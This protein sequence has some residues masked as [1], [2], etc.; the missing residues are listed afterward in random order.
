[1]AALV[2]KDP[3]EVT[4]KTA[5]ASAI[6]AAQAINLTLYTD[7]SAAAVTSALSSAQ[8]VYANAAA[9]QAQADAATA[10]LNGAVASLVLKQTPAE[11]TFLSG[12]YNG[13]N[14]KLYVP[15]SHASGTAAPLL[16]ML[17]G[18]GQTPTQFASE[19]QMN[20][21]ADERG[22]LVLYPEQPMSANGTLAW[23]W[24]SVAHQSRGSGEPAL[25]AGM[26]GAVKTAYTID[27]D[28]VFASGMGAGGAMAVILGA[29][30]PD[31]FHGIGVSS[32]LEYKAATSVLTAYTA[33]YSGGPSPATQGQLA[34]NA[35]GSYAAPVRLL[36]MQGS[37]DTTVY[38]VNGN[39]VLSQWAVTNDLAD[40]GTANGS[41]DDTAE[42]TQA[43]TSAG[44]KSYTRYVYENSG[45]D[46]LMEKY[47]VTGMGYG[48]P[49]GSASGSKT[50][51]TG[52][53]LSRIL[54]DFFLN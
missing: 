51:P 14:Y 49:G 24:F 9:T 40:D 28:R 5:L 13:R 29:T 32:G 33:M 41:V 10:A 15:A 52:P 22:F 48:W 18:S 27:S 46:I 30:Y 1:M 37:T 3:G 45:G 7:A 17:H 6:T 50:Q 20:A 16:V 35:M 31:V 38:P 25:I 54:C 19:T 21:L 42:L 53:D 8:T 43:G 39:Q 44:G 4:N 11:G 47:V 12:T 2:L 26:V 23:N 34:Y 36:V